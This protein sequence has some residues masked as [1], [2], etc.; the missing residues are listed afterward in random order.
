MATVSEQRKLV[1]RYIAAYASGDASKIDEIIAHNFIDH[2]YPNF[3]GPEGVAAGIRHVHEGL[4]DV[5]IDIE[6]FVCD[7]ESVAFLVKAA[8]THTGEFQGKPAT[9]NR[10]VW[11]LADF[12]RVKDGKFAELWNVSDNVALLL[13]IGAQVV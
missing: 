13:G 2:S 5:E 9:G 10:I 7:S 3:S 11:K 1:E 6:Y 8:G 4:S 12:V